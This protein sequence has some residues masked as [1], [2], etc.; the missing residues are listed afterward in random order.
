[1]T[2]NEELLERLD[3]EAV[4]LTDEE[5]CEAFEAL[6]DEMAR[7][8]LSALTGGWNYRR[9][10]WGRGHIQFDP[11]AKRLKDGSINVHGYW[12]FHY[13]VDGRRKSKYIGKD[14]KLAG[15]KEEN[16]VSFDGATDIERHST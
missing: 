15:W 7:R 14:F 16:P 2:G 10:T 1:M 3:R 13:I 12:Y 5:A 6:R 4:E 11:R 8:G 9:E